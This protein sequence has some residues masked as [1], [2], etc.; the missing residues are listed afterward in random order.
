M[1]VAPCSWGKNVRP[2][3]TGADAAIVTFLTARVLIIVQLRIRS[4]LV[5]YASSHA[6][7]GPRFYPAAASL[8]AGRN[9]NRYGQFFE[10]TRARFRAGGF[11]V[12]TTFAGCCLTSHVNPEVA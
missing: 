11:A 8:A 12:V 6:G 3:C 7:F 9:C 1:A 5:N 10:R 2:A 4:R